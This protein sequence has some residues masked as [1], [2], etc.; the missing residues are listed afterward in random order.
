MSLSLLEKT[1]RRITG[2]LVVALGMALLALGAWFAWA[3]PREAGHTSGPKRVTDYGAR[4]DGRADDTLAVQRAVDQ[5]GAI[6]FPRGDYRITRTIAIDLAKCGPV[7]LT[8]QGGVGRIIMAG[9]GP[10]F[11]LTG[12]HTGTADPESFK[13]GV[14]QRE[15]MPQIEALEIVGDHA[16]ADGIEFVRVMQPT[17]AR[18]L[19]RDVRHGIHLVERNRNLIIDSCHVYHCRGVGIFFDHVNLHQANIHGNHVSYCKG[20]GIK[21]VGSEIRNLQIVGNDIEYNYDPEAT[22]SADVWID[23]TGGSVREGAIVGNTI[24]AKISPGGA[25]LRLVGP[26]DI[27]KVSMFAVTGNHISNQEVNIHLKNCRGVVLSGNSLALSGR[28]NLLIEGSR[29]IVV[30]PHSLDHNPDYRRAADVLDGIALRSCDGCSLNGVLIEGA[31]A[32]ND[33]AGAAIELIDC[34]ETTL[35][36]CQI[37]EPRWRGIYVER[38]RNTRI[39][40]CTI[41]DRGDRP[42]MRAGIEVVEGSRGTRV[43]GNTIGRGSRSDVVM[44][45]GTGTAG[46]NQLPVR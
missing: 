14:W 36:G 16:E 37:F 23:S 1:M 6:Q 26:A 13:P 12:A 3:Q 35:S 19:I 42:T 22:E 41:T 28:R 8:G 21:A 34:R 4:G 20:G 18:V 25:N 2:T 44:A 7:S 15:R 17:L 45:E 39:T 29:H 33:K 38:C 30:G 10:A 31:A 5:G 43:V 32:G 40:G 11:R 46:D 9:P 27:N 24:Q